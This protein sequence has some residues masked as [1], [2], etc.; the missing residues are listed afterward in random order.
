[1]S[2]AA[3]KRSAGLHILVFLLPALL[4]YTV[5]MIYPLLST[6]GQSFFSNNRQF[7]GLQN[8][9][10]IVLDPR[11]FRS[12]WNAFRNNVWFFFIHIA[13]Q[14]PIGI[15]L[16][17]LLSGPG[18]KLHGFYRTVFFIPTTLSFVIVGFVWRLL[19][20]PTWGVAQSLLRTVGLGG[21]FEPWLGKEQYALTTLGLISV[22]QFVGTTMLLIYA[23]LLSVPDEMI[24]AAEC[25]GVVGLAQFWKIPLP[26]LLPTIGV[27][28]I[29]IFIG[30]FNAFDLIYV[31]EGPAAGPAF[32]TDLL[33]VLMFRTLYGYQVQLGDKAMGATVA[34]LMFLIIL[35]GVCGYLF[36]VQRRLRRYQL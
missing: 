34:S 23:A 3:R 22:W 14:I 6:L 13:F 25:D 30:N 16:A 17:A 27:C 8:Y 11:L 20:S 10:S 33:G 21:L 35:T 31:T 26:L 1:M 7:V 9:F 29:L 5:V 2:G 24:D 28:G 15:M 12:F 19:L 4:V 36:L 32:S 18:L